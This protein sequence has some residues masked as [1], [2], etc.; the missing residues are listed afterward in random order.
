LIFNGHPVG[1]SILGT[2]ETVKSFQRN[3]ILNFVKRNYVANRMVVASVGNIDFNRLVALIELYF[4]IPKSDNQNYKRIAFEQYT[5]TTKIVFKSNFQVHCILGTIA[6]PFKNKKRTILALLNNIL[7]GPGMNTRL[8]LNIRERYGYC[9]NIESHYQPFS[10]TGYFNI[11]LGTDN[12]YLDKSIQLIFKELRALKETKLGDLQ[13]HRSKQQIIGQLAISLESKLNEMISIGKSHLFF[14]E[15]DTFE[16]IAEKV[17]NV[18]ASELM[19]VANE[20][21]IPEKF[22]RLTYMPKD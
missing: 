10:D 6:Y 19:E 7:G 21:F 18:T 11:Y 4:K 16:K 2:P 13:L 3:S 9:Y 1:N 5:P 8:N 22:S 15:V 20:I 14:D 17:E 12:G